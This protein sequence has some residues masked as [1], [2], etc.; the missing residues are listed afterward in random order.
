MN[1]LTVDERVQKLTNNIVNAA[2]QS[3][4][5]K[6]VTVRPRDLPWFHNEIRKEIRKRNKAHKTE[7]ITSTPENWKKIQGS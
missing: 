5:N 3:I 7:K 4:P 1:D 2:E 6:I